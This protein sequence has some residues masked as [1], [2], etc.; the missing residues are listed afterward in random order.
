ML[1]KTELENRIREENL[2]KKTNIKR[3]EHFT[4]SER[5]LVVLILKSE[6]LTFEEIGS[7]LGCS[8][9]AVR[10]SYVAATH[11]IGWLNKLITN[12]EDK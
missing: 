6:G 3:I 5:M 10:Q 9:A 1:S 8:G 11:K 7:R 4:L 2:I 12:S